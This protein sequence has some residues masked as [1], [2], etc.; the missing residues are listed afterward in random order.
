MTK[1]KEEPEYRIEIGE[2][3]ILLD[4]RK[5]NLLKFIEEYGSITKASQK[6]KIPYRTALKY[7]E[8]LEQDLND[9]IVLTKRG[10]KGG[11]GGS[12]LTKTG[13]LLLREYKKVESVIDMHTDVNEIE[14]EIKEI[15]E[16]KKI[17]NIYFD[18]E[19]VILPLRG[20]FKVGDKVLIL[21]SP[22]DIFLTL[23]PLKS[24]VRNVFKGKITRMELKNQI[25][26]LNI[27]IGKISLFADVTQFAR[28]DLKLD[29][30]KEVF[31]GFKAAAIVVI[32]L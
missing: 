13:I 4:K 10:G 14:C 29:L 30:G 18:S 15:D 21:I 17:I 3:P 9:S 31:I 5:F 24:S 8:N 27:D 28:D 2:T 6:A 20:N 26:R 19:R 23:E 12:Q 11:G 32:K 7:I 16:K 25:V 22:E 1:L